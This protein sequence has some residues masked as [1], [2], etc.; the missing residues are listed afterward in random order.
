MSFE[1]RFKIIC[2]GCG[3]VL[4]SPIGRKI[5]DMK[6]P[7]WIVKQAAKDQHWLFCESRFWTTK[8]LCSACADSAPKKARKAV[9]QQ[10]KP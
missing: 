2:D 4:E 10:T 7:Y 1:V 6:R 5:S 3:Q 9:N 8:H